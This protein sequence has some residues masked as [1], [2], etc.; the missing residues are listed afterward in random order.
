MYGHTGQWPLEW[1]VYSGPGVIANSPAEGWQGRDCSLEALARLLHETGEPVVFLNDKAELGPRALGNRSILAAA[2]SPDMKTTLNEAKKREGYRPVAPICLAER[3]AE[4]FLP[5]IE[6]PYMLFD[7]RVRQEW[8]DRVPAIR[9]L[10]GTARVQTVGR[11]NN[12]QVYTL[13]KAYEA[14]SGVPLLCNT[15]ANYNGSGFFPDV[16]SAT[17]WGGVNYVWCDGQ[18]Y[19]KI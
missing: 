11:H 4:V 16:Y 9:H 14:L 2:T 1:S 19:Q 17:N 10:D 5:G 3:A 7:H 6:D 13:L 15:S 12:P 18:L 8:V